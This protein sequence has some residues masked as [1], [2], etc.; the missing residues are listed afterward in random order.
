MKNLLFVLILI[1]SCAPRDEEPQPIKITKV[2]SYG[3]WKVTQTAM[4]IPNS[5]TLN[6]Y[7]DGQNRT[8]TISSNETFTTHKFPQADQTGTVFYQQDP[9]YMDLTTQY[10]ELR[11]KVISATD[12]EITMYD[13]TINPSQSWKLKKQ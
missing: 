8:V 12:A 10:Y 9:A 7:A 3:T 1:T 5:S 6:W 2:D 11:M 4:H 13:S